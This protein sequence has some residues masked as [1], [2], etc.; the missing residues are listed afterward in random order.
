MPWWTPYTIELNHG[1]QWQI[2]PSTLWIF[3]GAHEWR[4]THKQASDSLMSESTI[5][6][7]VSE[8]EWPSVVDPDIPEDKIA[9]FSIQHDDPHVTLTPAL[10]DRPIV[11]RPENAIYIPPGED[12]TLYV[13]TP[14]W[15]QV[16]LG[17]RAKHEVPA[18][19]P[20][21]TW[22]GPSTREGELCYATRT[23]GRLQLDDLPLRPHRAVTPL[24]LQNRASD[25]LLLERI[26]IPMQHLALFAS[27]DHVV[28]TQAVTLHREEGTEGAR[29]QIEPGSP[30]D[31]PETERIA[32]PREEPKQNLVMSTF[33]ALGA[34]FSS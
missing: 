8:S 34:L 30:P 12:V 26:Q 2:G 23:T 22:F 21:D 25:Q 9:R 28:W 18:Y 31:I 3:H 14:L 19:R 13:S 10:A 32:E 33:K 5:R 16:E 11:A 15:I 6:G 4:L 29:V 27:P 20:S 24:L 1:S 7:P 17:G